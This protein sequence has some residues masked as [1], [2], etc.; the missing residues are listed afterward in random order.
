MHLFLSS[1]YLKIFTFNIKFD[2]KISLCFFSPRQTDRLSGRTSFPKTASAA[3]RNFP[4]PSR[5]KRRAARG[6][7]H[8]RGTPAVA[9]NVLTGGGCV[10]WRIAVC[11][12]SPAPLSATILSG[13]WL[14][15]ARLGHCSHC[16]DS[17]A[18]EGPATYTR[19][20]HCRRGAV[21]ISLVS[22]TRA[23]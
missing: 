15:P 5:G 6:L 2:D 19:G 22:H 1:L 9:R 7:P 4:V 16:R 3:F 10:A 21:V 14:T 20:W 11:K 18:E 23:R 12:T 17:I 13:A 8:H